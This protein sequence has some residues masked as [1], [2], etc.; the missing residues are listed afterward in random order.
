MHDEACREGYD[1]GRGSFV[2]H[3]GLPELD[4][5]LLLIPL[6]GF[7]PAS[8]PRVRNTV[9]AVGRELTVDGLVRR[10]RP[11]QEEGYQAVFVRL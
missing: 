10:Y 11:R 9:E 8:D 2:Q 7:L 6:V 4:A 5:S 1:A 3:Y